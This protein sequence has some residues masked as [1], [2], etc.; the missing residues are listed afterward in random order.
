[1]VM[2]EFIGIHELL[3]SARL[4]MQLTGHEFEIYTAES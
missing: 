1:M 3:Q 2:P 4:V